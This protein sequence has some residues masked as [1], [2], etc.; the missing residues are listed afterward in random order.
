MLGGGGA[1]GAKI[2]TCISVCG[3]NILYSTIGGGGAGSRWRTRYSGGALSVF[4]LTP[5]TGGGGGGG[6][7]LQWTNQGLMVD[8]VVVDFC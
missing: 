5:T 3:G 8:Q 6:G 2:V 4:H 1:G 7:G